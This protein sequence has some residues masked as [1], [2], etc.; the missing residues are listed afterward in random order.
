MEQPGS[1]LSRAACLQRRQRPVLREHAGGRLERLAGLLLA[2]LQLP[3]LAAAQAQP[4]CCAAACIFC[5]QAVRIVL[6]HGVLLLS[7]H[8]LYRRIHLDYGWSL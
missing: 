5:L 1:I 4:A 2:M 6:G 7:L 8:C 3:Q